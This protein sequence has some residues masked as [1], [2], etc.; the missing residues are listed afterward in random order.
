MD[1]VLFS[2]GPI[3]IYWYS[4]IMLIAVLVGI[5][6]SIKESKKEALESFV[7]DLITYIIVF[8]II[9]ARLYYVIFNFDNYKN[10]L[11]SIFKIWEGGIAIYGAIIGGFIAIVYLA[12]KRDKSII[13]TTDIIVPGLILAQSIGRWGNFFNGEAHGTEVSLEFLKSL[14]LPN[15]II[16]GMHI[17]GAYYHPTFLYESLWCFLGFII[18]MILRKITKRKKGIIT[19]SYFIWY[20]IGRL[21]IEGLRT[22]SLYLGNYRI[23]QIVSIILVILGII[24]IIISV[25]K[26]NKNERKI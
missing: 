15:F 2:I 21:F 5:F 25:V 10:N 23:S 19:S 4:I 24:G 26:G 7:S 3:T 18:L 22:D 12:K 20:G 13:K 9:G 11:L 16:E 8:G 6:L 17:N 14:H 1:R